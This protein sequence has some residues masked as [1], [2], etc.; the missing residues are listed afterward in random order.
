MTTTVDARKHGHGRD[1]AFRLARSVKR[2]VAGRGKT[3]VTFRSKVHRPL[4]HNE[5]VTASGMVKSDQSATFELDPLELKVH[6][7]PPRT[8]QNCS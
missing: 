4:D 3:V 2:V 8:P 1:E 5:A 6:A 7:S